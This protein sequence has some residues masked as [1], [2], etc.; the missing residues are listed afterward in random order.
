MSFRKL[1]NILNKV[2]NQQLERFN[3]LSNLRAVHLP[4]LMIDK[5]WAGSIT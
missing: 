1:K 5:A 3:L 2:V 4:F